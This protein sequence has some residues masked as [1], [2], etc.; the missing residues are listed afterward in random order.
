MAQFDVYSLPNDQGML[1]VDLQSGAVDEFNT[2]LMAPLIPLDPGIKP[3]RRVN[4]E[5]T[6]D[7]RTFLFMPQLMS[8]VR[9]RD[10]GKPIGNIEDQRDR[11]VGALDVLF[12]G[13]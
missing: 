1:F 3:L 2:R 9:T 11:I 4:R 6:F 8:A 10:L 13:V 12:V 7:S 5:L